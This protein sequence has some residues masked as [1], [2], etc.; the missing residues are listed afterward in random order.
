MTE[1]A[2][3]GPDGS[4]R[5]GVPFSIHGEGL[6]FRPWYV[7]DRVQ[8]SKERNLVRHANFCGL[9]D[10][11]EIHGKN[12]EIHISGNLLQS[13]LGS[14][15]D[16]LDH[17]RTAQLITAAWS[18]EVRVVQGEYEGPIGWDATKNEYLWSYNVD[19]VSTGFN[20]AGHLRFYNK[21]IVED[22]RDSLDQQQQI[23][24]EQR[25]LFSGA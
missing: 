15:E 24:P 8:V 5:R 25:R 1:L 14:F 20:E 19:L 23:T 21:G 10:V 9:E 17:N 22:G 12:R 18:G 6:E 3:G 2:F 4:R 16:V 11:F 7:P 13:D